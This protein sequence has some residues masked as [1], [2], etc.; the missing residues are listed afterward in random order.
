MYATVKTSTMGEF[1]YINFNDG[2]S[3]SVVYSLMGII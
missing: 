2:Y 1:E 3:I